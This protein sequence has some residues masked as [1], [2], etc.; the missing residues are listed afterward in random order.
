MIKILLALKRSLRTV[1]SELEADYN[2]DILE[3]DERLTEK[4]LRN[5][6]DAVIVEQDHRLLPEI[7]TIDP[8]AEVIILGC[9]SVD[10]LEAVRLGATECI[11]LP[12]D[13]A[14]LRSCIDNIESVLMERRE[15]GK[16][17]RQLADLYTFSGVVGKNPHMLEIFNFTRRIAPY[18]RT[19]TIMGETGT[20]KE[21]LAKALHSIS[22][23]AKEPFVICNCGSL[24]ESLIESELF[25]H[26][27]GSFTGAIA[28]HAGVF[29][30]AGDGTVF[31]DEVGE[32]PLPFQPHLLRVLQSG[33]FRRVGDERPMKA[34]C[35]IIAATNRDLEDEVRRGRMRED[36]Y[37]RLTPLILRLPALRERKDD[38]P[39]L[40]RV[41][42]DRAS[43]RT[44]KKVFGFSRPAQMAL[45]SYDWPG[46][47]RELENVIEQVTMLTNEPFIRVEDLPAGIRDHRGD[48]GRFTPKS[49]DEVVCSHI[50]AT[51]AECNG[52]RSNA[53]KL[54]G[55]SRRALLRKM[56]KYSLQ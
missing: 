30:A 43:E 32:L 13:L 9:G 7:K 48:N 49:L 26:K 16:L 3:E 25:G 4:M 37:F 54:L 14:R 56:E 24:V 5:N 11:P 33:D 1:A 45:M 53:A 38:I 8:R 12:L 29:E 23:V 55:I 21:E 40:T 28:D 10:E 15:T 31:L 50:E 47:I 6:Y 2:I 42:L 51:L 41:L 52:N 36:L 20:G 35:R 18:F 34:R 44:G 22:P 17:E 39:L 46:N 27:K 19:I